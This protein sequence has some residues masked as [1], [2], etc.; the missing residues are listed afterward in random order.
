MAAAVETAQ[1]TAKTAEPEATCKDYDELCEKLK[2][3]STLGGIRYE[4]ELGCAST[5]VGFSG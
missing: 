4:K 3:L 1:Q 2:E 5:D